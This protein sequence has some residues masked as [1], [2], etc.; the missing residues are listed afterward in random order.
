MKHLRSILTLIIL[1]SINQLTVSASNESITIKE[2]YEVGDKLPNI[3][4]EGINGNIY[5]LNDLKGKIVLVDFWA[6]WCGPCRRENPFVVKTY[7][8]YK[9]K[10]FTVCTL[11]LQ[12]NL[13]LI[14]FLQIFL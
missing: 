11:L 6:S 8:K 7:K 3:S 14:A 10:G 13:G 1:I 4:A 9:N 5:N 2:G 12:Q